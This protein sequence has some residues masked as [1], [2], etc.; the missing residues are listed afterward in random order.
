MCWEGHPGT[1]EQLTCCIRCSLIKWGK[2]SWLAFTEKIQEGSHVRRWVNHRHQ[3]PG[4]PGRYLDYFHT[5][6]QEIRNWFRPNDHY[7]SRWGEEGDVEVKVVP[8]WPAQH[9]CMSG[10]YSP[11]YSSSKW[12]WESF[13]TGVSDHSQVNQ[14]SSLLKKENFNGQK[15]I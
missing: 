6:G 5:I 1:T 3:E 2:L 4:F 13:L 12:Q 9:I 7:A 11:I 8:G 10:F 15:W 14:Y